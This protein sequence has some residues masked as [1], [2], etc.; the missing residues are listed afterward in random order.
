MVRLAV[1][2]KLDEQAAFV[3]WW[4]ENVRGKGAKAN[5]ADQRYF[6]ADAEHACRSIMRVRSTM[7]SA[8]LF[9]VAVGSAFLA[10]A[11]LTILR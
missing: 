3:E 2:E 7:V 9:V 11:L 8:L 5:S 4:R 1:D 10:V 6:Q